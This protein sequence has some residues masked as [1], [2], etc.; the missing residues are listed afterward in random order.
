VQASNAA[1]ALSYWGLG[2]PLLQQTWLQSLRYELEQDTTAFRAQL[3]SLG[4]WRGYCEN[5]AAALGDAVWCK[6]TLKQWARCQVHPNE[7]APVCEF[8]G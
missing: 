5:A 1:I 3:T 4:Y 6:E 8:A 2:T 7:T